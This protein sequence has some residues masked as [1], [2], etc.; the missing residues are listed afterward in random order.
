V[1]WILWSALLLAAASFV[2]W[3]LLRHWQPEPEVATVVDAREEHARQLEEL[4]LD[5]AAGRLSPEE[6]ARRRAELAS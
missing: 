2:F 3:P 5:Q 1:I 4:E 6:A